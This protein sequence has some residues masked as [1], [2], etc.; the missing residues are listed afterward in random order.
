[1]SFNHNTKELKTYLNG[2]LVAT[3]TTPGNAASDNTGIRIARRSDNADYFD[4]T[5][6]D[7]KIWNGVL[8]PSEITNQ[9]HSIY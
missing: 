7:I 8:S 2:T 5:V 4:C 1:V 3:I 6:K 9:T